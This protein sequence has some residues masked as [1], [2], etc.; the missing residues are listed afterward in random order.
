MPVS[1]EILEFNP[2]LDQS[3]GDDPALVNSDPY[4]DGWIV[5]IR[6]TDLAQ[7]KGLMDAKAYSSMVA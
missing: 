3:E 1:G 5:K 6:M 4:T 7:L 2:K